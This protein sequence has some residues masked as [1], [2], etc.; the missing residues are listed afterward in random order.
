MPLSPFNRV[1]LYWEQHG[2][3]GPPLVLVHGSWGDHHNWDAVVPGLAR[4]FRVFTYD[5]RGHSQSERPPTQGSIDEDVD[6]LAAFIETSD[7]AP[8]NVVG[9]SFGAAIALKLAASK[10]HLF[11]TLATHEPPL[12][13]MIADHPMLPMVQQ[14]V[15]AVLDLL[16]AGEME[17]G[18]EQFVETVGLGPGMWAQL[19]PEMQ[20]TFVFNAPTFL[21][22]QNEPPTAMRVDLSRLAMFRRP[23]LI[24]RGDQ[25]PPF[26]GLI[27]DR[28]AAALP[29]AQL[30]TFRGG[31]HVPHVTHPEEYVETVSRFV[32]G[33][34]SV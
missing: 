4:A 33:A 25:S 13:G 28:I 2:R 21:D 18:A 14:R 23:A 1:Q 15:D 3:P 7:L 6:D 31:G 27:L 22:E 19:P 34:A 9:N 10:P 26:F 16:R 17:R 24:T 32:H 30:H 11:A 12:L 29:H 5:R 8:A 20:R